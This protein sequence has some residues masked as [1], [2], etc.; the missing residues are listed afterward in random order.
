MQNSLFQAI[1]RIGIFMI[2]ARAIIQF[3]PREVYEKY[4]RFLVGIMILIQIFLPV[5]RLVL[6]KE[7]G[8]AGDVLGQFR[9]ELERGMEEAAEEARE[10]DAILERMT[11][12][13]VRKLLEEESPSAGKTAENGETDSPEGEDAGT[14][15]PVTIRIGIEPVE[16]VSPVE[17][18]TETAGQTETGG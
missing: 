8:Q 16:P 6:G 14:G 12:E 9:Q 7:G 3:R 10:A 17:G 5:G 15:G 18:E 2:C 13:E 1:C 11:L 4:L